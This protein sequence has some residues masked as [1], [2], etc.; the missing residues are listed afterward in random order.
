MSSK[1]QAILDWLE[2]NRR[3]EIRVHYQM[4]SGNLP[5]GA[6]KIGG[7]P[8]VPAD[9]VWPYVA[10]ESLY[11][12]DDKPHP[13]TF[14]AQFNLAEL[15]DCDT[16][17]RL[18]KAGLLSFFYND[19]YG[20]GED[21][22]KVFYFPPEMSLVRCPLPDDRSKNCYDEYIDIG[23]LTVSFSRQSY[24]PSQNRAEEAF[25]DVDIYDELQGTAEYEQFFG[26]DAR[27]GC[28]VKLFGWAEPVQWDME[29][30]CQ[31]KSMGLDWE[32]YRNNPKI[33]AEVKQG[34]DDWVLLFQ[35]DS[36]YVEDKNEVLYPKLQNIS[37]ELRNLLW[38]YSSLSSIQE[39]LDN[40]EVSENEMSF[41][42]ILGQM[43]Q[44]L[45][46]QLAAEQERNK[47]R[48]QEVSNILQK[49]GITP[50]DDL[51]ER[52]PNHRSV[53]I[54]FGDAGCLYFWIH[55]DDL[56]AKRFDKVIFITQC[57]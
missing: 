49:A 51:F 4:S 3:P 46:E 35:L 2:K 24:V 40:V 53:D 5:I 15:A 17:N 39:T 41:L 6:S 34:K 1:A 23:E 11:G 14:M 38:E 36:I 47:Q 9:F 26:E 43:P 16:E 21:C 56:A 10:C 20:L 19:E 45:Q 7:C 32:D 48:I 29:E 31:L 42:D 52:N 12:D 54:M 28:T 37:E 33:Q 44:D 30:A 55:K 13:L 8:D 50:S 18:P 57:H 25:P 22:A 27:R